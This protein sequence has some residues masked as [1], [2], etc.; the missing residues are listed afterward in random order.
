VAVAVAVAV[1]VKMRGG[2]GRCIRPQA[3]GAII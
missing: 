2:T 1:Q 3:S